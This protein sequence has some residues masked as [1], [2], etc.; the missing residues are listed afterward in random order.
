MLPKIEHPTYKI[1]IPSTQKNQSFRP[2]LVKEEKLLLIAKESG[3]E[4]DIL[5]AI[6]QVVTNCSLDKNLDTNKLSIFDLEYVFL[7]IRAFSI[8][9]IVK[10]A[11]RDDEDETVYNFEVNLNDVNVKF[12]KKTK[13]TIKITEN[14]GLILKYPS[15]SLYDDQEFLNTEN[16]HYF[17]LI[18]KCVDKIYFDEEV[19][20]VKD[21]PKKELEEFIENLKVDVFKQ[22]NEFLTNAPRIEHVLSYTNKNG[23]KR[24]IY[25]NSLND[26]F[27][28]R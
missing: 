4:T 13:E 26:F 17:E 24:E 23:S 10:I 7:K 16:N 11:Y 12:P 6:K 8:D 15:A 27:T 22:V 2:F 25:L 5:T 28:W 21:I 19:Y 9:N 20:E 3:N 18:L 14:I 1:K